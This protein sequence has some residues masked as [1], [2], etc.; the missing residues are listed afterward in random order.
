MKPNDYVKFCPVCNET[1]QNTSLCLNNEKFREFTKGY[2]Y[3]FE[4]NNSSSTICPCCEKGKLENSPL[5]FE[6]FKIIDEVSNSDRQ[7]LEAMIDLKQKDPIEY[8]LKMS[9]FKANL[10]QQESAKQ[11]VEQESNVPHCPTCSSTDL[12]KI[13]TTSKI[14]NTAMWGIFGTKRHKTYHCNSCGYEW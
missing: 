12:K 3:L 13:S 9:Q 6:E 5:T 7:F 4:P 1:K 11:V 10:S 14:M 2:F 8:Q